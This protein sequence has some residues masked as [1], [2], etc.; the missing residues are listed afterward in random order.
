M[1]KPDIYVKYVNNV[2]A[3]LVCDKAIKYEITE[4]FSYT[5]KNSQY[6]PL[7][8][9]R[10]WDG[11]TRLFRS[12]TQMLPVGLLFHLYEFCTM[13]GYS[14]E[15]DK[16]LMSIDKIK[17][18][19]LNAWIDGLNITSGGSEIKPYWY[20]YDLLKYALEVKRTVVLA[21]TSAGKSLSIY[22]LA[23]YWLEQGWVDVEAGKKVLIIV[24]STGL[25]E[26]MYGDFEDYSEYDN[27]FDTEDSVCKLYSGHDRDFLQ[28]D[29]VI[30][31]WQ[32]LQNMDDDYFEQFGGVMVDEV[33]GAKADKLQKIMKALDT[34]LRVG[35]TGT[36]DDMH[37][38]VLK[39]ESMFGKAHRIVKSHQLQEGGQASELKIYAILLKHSNEAARFVHDLKKKEKRPAQKFQIEMDYIITND[40]RNLM[41]CDLAESLPGNTLI[42]YQFVEK[43]GEPLYE[44]LSKRGLK[45]TFLIN[46]DVS[47]V[48]RN[49]IKKAM[50]AESG[51]NCV[52]SYGTTSTGW[53]VKN[54]H[55]II[56]ASPSKSKIRVL[57]SIGRGMRLH[58]SKDQCSIFDIG[59]DLSF[60]NIPNYT[61]EH[62]QARIE[63]YYKEMQQVEFKQVDFS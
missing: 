12:S 4:F 48:Q 52:A 18:D 28:G 50:E 13:N 34:P 55:N 39:V 43:Q 7:V 45:K 41:I 10:K 60:Q 24:P 23:R 59:D 46:K 47:A 8:K 9:A 51:C 21:A 3:H 11:V 62:M 56:L 44:E 1:P 49:E 40:E 42:L 25:V 26:Q 61:L 16:E 30:S 37:V 32:S 29:I 5:D 53:S 57:Q 14:I 20:Q 19:E 63:M 6:H 36:L 33:H 2:D 15:F 35:L 22:L 54:L 31:T 58:D 17:D 27:S 38:H